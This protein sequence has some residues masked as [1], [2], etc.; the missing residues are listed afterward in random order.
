MASQRQ[1]TGTAADYPFD[2]RLERRVEELD[3]LE[4]LRA[5]RDRYVAQQLYELFWH[6]ESN[7]DVIARNLRRAQAARAR[8]ELEEL[9]QM[10]ASAV[11][12]VY[13]IEAQELARDIT[14][15]GADQSRPCL[16][17][18]RSE[19]RRQGCRRVA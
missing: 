10:A 18:L 12:G 6:I 17:H 13:G 2:P 5:I 11:R 7:A 15:R 3:G 14:Q 19:L 8:D 4:R 9:R 1:Q 16:E